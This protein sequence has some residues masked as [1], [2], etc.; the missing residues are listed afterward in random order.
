MDCSTPVVGR[1]FALDAA[2]VFELDDLKG[3]GGI[4]VPLAV[5]VPA[6]APS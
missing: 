1:A 6:P 3:S 5:D 2:A 4:T